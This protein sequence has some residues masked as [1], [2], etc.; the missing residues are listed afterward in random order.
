MSIFLSLRLKLG[1]QIRFSYYFFIRTA[2]VLS[3]LVDYQVGDRKLGVA[4][5]FR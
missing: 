4:H 2:L 5:S 1:R 3:L